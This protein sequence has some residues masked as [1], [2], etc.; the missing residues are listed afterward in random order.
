MNR[1]KY[2]L[3]ILILTLLISSCSNMQVFHMDVLKPG[4]VVVPSQKNN[5]VLVDNSGVQPSY[6]GH[7]VKIGFKLIGDTSFNTEP[8]SELLFGSLSNYLLKEGFYKRITPWHRGTILP[9]KTKEGEYLRSGRISNSMI[10]EIS[11]DTS[12]HLLISLDRLLTTTT[13]NTYYTGETYLATRDVWVNSVWRVYDLDQDTLITQFQY[14]DSL[15]WQKNSQNP[16]KVTQS[17]P[18]IDDVLPEIGDV[19]AEHLSRVMGPHWESEKREYFCTGSYRMK[20]AADL[21]RNGS[22]D[23]AATLWKLEFEKGI[24]RSKYRAAMNMMFYEELKGNP[25]EALVWCKKAEEAML[26]CPIGSA[27]YDVVYLNQRKIALE[28]RVEDV[29]KLKIYFDGNLN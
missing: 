2:W 28:D 4:Y 17:L 19:V 1:S 8:L 22:I 5:I 15:Y 18:L 10:R 29:Q 9:V 24:F 20:M 11:R 26:Q 12:V 3:S 6:M 14:N 25:A 21:V 23:E 7:E 27:D 16:L 13:T